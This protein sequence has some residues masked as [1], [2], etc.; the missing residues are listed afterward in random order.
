[1]TSITRIV[2]AVDI[3]DRSLSVFRQALTIAR[4]S[5]AKLLLVCPVSPNERFSYRATERVDYLM[6]L[7]AE[8]EAARV[9][10]HA[11]VQTG[12]AAEIIL[13]HARSRGADLIVIGAAHGAVDGRSRGSVA[14]DVL[15]GAGS[16]TLVVRSDAP[17]RRE[18]LN[19]V[20]AVDVAD[21]PERV[22]GSAL[23]L[24]SNDESRVT[25]MHVVPART[26][27]MRAL[28]RLQA[29]VPTDRERAVRVQ[30]RSGQVTRQIAEAVRSPWIDLLVIGARRRHRLARRLFGVTRSLL[31]EAGCPVLAVPLGETVVEALPDRVAA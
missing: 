3:D 18:V 11:S 12:E 21:A 4:A 8:A 28:R 20:A 25:L 15:R 13:L 7:R 5:D 31:S 26:R 22:V 27:P 19:V 6:K 24:T 9:D 23:R 17:P 16:P 10:V 29:M 30:V 2:C 14:E 1:M